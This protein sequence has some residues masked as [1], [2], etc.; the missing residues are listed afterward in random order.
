[1][2]DPAPEE[3]H[4]VVLDNE[5]AWRTGNRSKAGNWFDEDVSA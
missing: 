5:A 4:G 1:M 2:I 3:V